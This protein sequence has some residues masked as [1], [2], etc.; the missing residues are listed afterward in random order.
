MMMRQPTIQFLKEPLVEGPTNTEGKVD[1][2][3]APPAETENAP[4]PP[5]EA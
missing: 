2:E 3:N 1:Q 5:P 4:L